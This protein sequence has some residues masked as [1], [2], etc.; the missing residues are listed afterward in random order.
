MQALYFDP[1]TQPSLALRADLSNPVAE[2]GEALIGLRLAGICQT[3]L[4]ITHGYLGFSG[5]LGH[6]FVG[7]LLA[8][9]QHASGIWPAGQR[10]V[11]EINVACR[12]CA[13]CLT[14]MESQC[15]QR[16]TMGIDRYP[17]AFAETIRLPIANLYPVPDSVPDEMA[18]FAEP[19]AAAYQVTAITPI[20]PTDK[21]V[22]LG[23]GKL[24]L[25]VAQV[26]ALTGCDLVV[27]ARQPKPL[28]LL[29]QWGIA[30]IDAR[31][32][33]WQEAVGKQSAHI[34]IDCTGTAEGFAQAL[35]LVRP[36]GVIHLKS[37]YQ[38]L[39]QADLTRV[40]ID[41]IA[42]HSSRCGPFA[43][44]LRGMASNKLDLAGLIEAVYPIDQALTAF[45][46]AAGRGVLKVLL[47]A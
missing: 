13:Y 28:A 2:A 16:S 8:D 35:G 44:A 4:E 30:H 12:Q 24:G 46:H 45:N 40:V 43:A 20:R 33:G 5:I 32:E 39:P 15:P 14:G 1:Q 23:A 37:T 38:G 3:D 34:V 9:V 27:V 25:L 21:V 47:Q 31:V 29:K 36:R 6:E 17:G 19:L 41:E 18:V 10:V 26:V 11:G 22:L 42:I 7:H